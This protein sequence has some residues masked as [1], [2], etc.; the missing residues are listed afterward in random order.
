MKIFVFVD[1]AKDC[2]TL[3]NEDDFL[4]NVEVFF[5][6]LKEQCNT[7]QVKFQDVDVFDH[8]VLANWKECMDSH[9]VVFATRELKEGISTQLE[10]IMKFMKDYACVYEMTA[11]GLV[12][13]P[14]K[15]FSE[16]ILRQHFHLVGF[17]DYII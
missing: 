15:S 2:W 4:Q 6:E 3:T 9:I 12:S 14:K 5:D 1:F 17:Y 13:G 7:L 16:E 10:T 8:M 11:V